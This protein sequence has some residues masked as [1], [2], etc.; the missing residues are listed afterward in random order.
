MT[1]WILTLPNVHLVFD[2][3]DYNA[4][5]IVAAIPLQFTGVR[6]PQFD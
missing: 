2:G 4:D 3:V 6:D 1:A 5:D